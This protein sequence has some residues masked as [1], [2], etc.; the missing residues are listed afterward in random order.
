MNIWE[1]CIDRKSG[2]RQKKKASTLPGIKKSFDIRTCSSL[3]VFIRSDIMDCLIMGISCR[4]MSTMRVLSP[5]HFTD[6]CPSFLTAVH[7]SPSASSSG[8]SAVN[9]RACEKAIRENGWVSSHNTENNGNPSSREYSRFVSP[10][11][12]SK[13]KKRSSLKRTPTRPQKK[14]NSESSPFVFR[15]VLEISRTKVVYSTRRRKTVKLRRRRESKTNREK[16]EIFHLRVRTRRRVPYF[17]AG[18][19]GGLTSCGAHP[20]H[21]VGPLRFWAFG[22]H[23]GVLVADVAKVTGLHVG[24]IVCRYHPKLLVCI[25]NVCARP[26]G[27][28]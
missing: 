23:D 7:R 8:G 3:S 4:H 20:P 19:T 5:T 9:S 15:P 18:R 24:S 13:K 17:R 1:N 27:I 16:T 22:I 14:R 10:Q 2:S 21:M 26:M 28:I 25:H 6:S 11:G 12:K